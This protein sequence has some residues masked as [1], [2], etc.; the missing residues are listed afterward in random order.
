MSGYGDGV[1]NADLWLLFILE[2]I[3]KENKDIGRQQSTAIFIRK[4]ICPQCNTNAITF[5][6]RRIFI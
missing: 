4:D 6:I 2:P 1:G 3:L 5:F